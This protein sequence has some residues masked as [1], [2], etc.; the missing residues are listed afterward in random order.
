MSAYVS[1]RAPYGSLLKEARPAK[2]NARPARDED[3]KHLAAVRQCPCLSC[4][5]S[6]NIEAAHVRMSRPGKP[7][8]GPGMKPDDKYTLPLCAGCHRT[9]PDAQHEVGEPKFYAA[10]NMEPLAICEK[11]YEASPD[12]D[13]MRAVISQARQS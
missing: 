12:V 4:G 1:P 3:P 13:A 8:A 2:H 6:N 10:L 9:K 7:N 11:L 5:R